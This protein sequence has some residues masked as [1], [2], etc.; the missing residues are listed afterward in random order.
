MGNRSSN[1]K[2]G[3]EMYTKVDTV[4]S[5]A[6]AKEE[7]E[8]RSMS[9]FE[10][11]IVLRPYFWPSAGTDGA[12]VNRCRSTATWLM[13][14]LSKTSNLASPY[15]LASATNAVTEGR[16]KL[17]ARD[18]VLYCSLRATSSLFKGYYTMRCF[19]CLILA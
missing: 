2:A 17:A 8:K 11:M 12:F 16:Y 4:E 1:A 6:A 10:L 5:T 14:A 7:E 9:F 3:I 18:L 19:V 15:F 13:V